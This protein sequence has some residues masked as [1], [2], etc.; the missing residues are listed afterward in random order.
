MTI[1][2]TLGVVLLALILFVGEWFP[3][4][5]TAITVMVILMT[6]GRVPLQFGDV[7]LVQGPKQSLLGLQTLPGFVLT[8]QRD[9]ETLRRD[10]AWVASLSSL[11][12]S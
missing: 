6:L 3:A 5:I 4:D 8:Q 2:L 10:R 11:S 7:L 1:A 9:R 12:P